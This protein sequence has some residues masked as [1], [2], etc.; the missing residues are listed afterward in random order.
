MFVLRIDAVG[1]MEG[2][3]RKLRVFSVV[4][5]VASVWTGTFPI[6]KMGIFKL[7][8]YLGKLLQRMKE[9]SSA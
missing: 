9:V 2:A 8:H 6:C 3:L 1:G 4:L 7:L 5:D